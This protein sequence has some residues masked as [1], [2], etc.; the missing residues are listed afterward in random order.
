MAQYIEAP[1]KGFVA[2]EAVAQFLRVHLSSGEI[3]V[4]GATDVEIGTAETPTFGSDEPITVRLRTAQGTVKMVASGSIT[5]GNDVYRAAS[6]KVASSGDFNL[7]T[8]L[9]AAS[10]DGSVI[11][12]LPH[13]GVIDEST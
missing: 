3:E 6:G 4:A 11:E 8:A 12:V 7:G 2:S 13:N 10:G 5:A 9:E 1:T